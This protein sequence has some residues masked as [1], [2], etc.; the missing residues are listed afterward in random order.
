MLISFS[1]LAT[2]DN[3]S[4][5][6][7]CADQLQRCGLLLEEFERQLHDLKNNAFR[8]CFP[9]RLSSFNATI[10]F[11]KLKN[12]SCIHEKVAFDECFTKSLQ[13]VRG[14]LFDNPL[15]GIILYI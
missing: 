5:N 8:S 11:K 9:K 7:Q 6:S 12:F 10:E 2:I 15:F 13:A 3:I 14:P 4:F 1:I